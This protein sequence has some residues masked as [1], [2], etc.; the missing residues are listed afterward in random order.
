MMTRGQT[1]MPV[2]LAFSASVSNHD[3]ADI[4]VD[5]IFAG[6]AGAF[7]VPAFWAGGDVFRVRFAAPEPGRYAYRTVC[8]GDS[9]GPTF[10]GTSNTI[11]AVHSFGNDPC[12]NVSG[13][14]RLDTESARSFLRGYD[15]PL[16]SP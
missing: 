5:V 11:V 10:L 13:N 12:H 6:P 7:R 3:I 2:E 4:E 15:V 8:S 16:P 1:N 9:G 14:V